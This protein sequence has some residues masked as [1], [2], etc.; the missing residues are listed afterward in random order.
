MV[1]VFC[2]VTVL[3]PD[4]DVLDVRL[5]LFQQTLGLVPLGL[6]ENLLPAVCGPLAPRLVNF[7]RA[8]RAFLTPSSPSRSFLSPLPSAQLA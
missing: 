1:T 4:G 8:F 7:S 5:Y 3:G 2:L 6:R